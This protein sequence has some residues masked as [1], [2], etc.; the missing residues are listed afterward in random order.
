MCS[1]KYHTYLAESR[2]KLPE[3]DPPPLA[4]LG[5]LSATQ[6]IVKCL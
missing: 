6:E 4:E 2:D 1:Y 5:S 3:L